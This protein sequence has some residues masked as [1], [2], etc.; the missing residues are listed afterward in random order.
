MIAFVYV[1]FYL[2]P[3]IYECAKKIKLKSRKRCRRNDIL[4]KNLRDK[5]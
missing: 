4:I 1:N 3:F 2:N 5:D